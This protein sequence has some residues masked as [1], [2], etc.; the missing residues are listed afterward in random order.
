MK[1]IGNFVKYCIVENAVWSVVSVAEVQERNG[2]KLRFGGKT[3]WKLFHRLNKYHIFK[4]DPGRRVYAA[5][6]SQ[7]VLINIFAALRDLYLDQ[8]MLV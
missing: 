6:R 5:P 1:L 8:G 7:S 4:E 3:Y 2:L